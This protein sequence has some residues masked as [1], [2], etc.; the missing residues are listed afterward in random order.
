MQILRIIV[1]ISLVFLNVVVCQ[2]SSAQ[3]KPKLQTKHLNQTSKLRSALNKKSNALLSSQSTVNPQT[4]VLKQYLGAKNISSVRRLA[5][6]SKNKTLDKTINS[7]KPISNLPTKILN[8]KNSSSAQK[9]NNL[10][11]KKI[12][13][14]SQTKPAK[15]NTK[16]LQINTSKN[17]VRALPSQSQMGQRSNTSSKARTY[18]TSSPQMRSTMSRAVTQQDPLSQNA[19][20]PDIS[21]PGDPPS[22][23]FNASQRQSQIPSSKQTNSQ[24]NRQQRGV[25]QQDPFSPNAPPPNISLPGDS[26]SIRFNASQT[27]NTRSQ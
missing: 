22:L 21:L 7:K 12:N 27:Q 26:P 17:S 9:Q 5:S 10:P 14:Q 3:N 16:K 1:L 25:T 18:A 4:K 8:Q 13:S 19:T 23:R 24:S 11:V 6:N 20:P 15:T 2:S